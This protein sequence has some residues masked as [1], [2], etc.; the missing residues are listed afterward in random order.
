MYFA[1]SWVSPASKPVGCPPVVLA[2]ENTWLA[3]VPPR[4]SWSLSL[5]AV[6]HGLAAMASSEATG[7]EEIT[8]AK[9]EPSPLS[10]PPPRSGPSPVSEEQAAR[11]IR[12]SAAAAA[13]TVRR[14]GRKLVAVMDL[15]GLSGRSGWSGL[16]GGWVATRSVREDL[17]QERAGALG[18]RGGEE[19]LR[20][21]LLDDLALVHVDDAV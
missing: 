3:T 8:S 14:P 15:S 11:P 20:I 2:R 7:P 13:T 1:S 12:G 10:S 9:A 21:A 4:T 17:G 19:L 16:G 18:A 5:I 6:A